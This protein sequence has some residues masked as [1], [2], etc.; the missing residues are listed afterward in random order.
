[1]QSVRIFIFVYRLRSD[2]QQAI[3][4]I[5]ANR[6]FFSLTNETFVTRTDGDDCNDT[7]EKINSPQVAHY[8]LHAKVVENT[9]SRCL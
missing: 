7:S 5:Y 4:V 6:D 3:I 1:M 8:I 9:I 2:S